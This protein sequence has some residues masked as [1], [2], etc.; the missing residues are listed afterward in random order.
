METIAY[1]RLVMPGHLNHSETL[2]GGDLLKWA[3]EAAALYVICQLKSKNVVTLKMSEIL[4]KE[5]VYNGDF[6]IFYANTK[7]VGNSSITIE[8]SVYKKDI[9]Q[10]SPDI[11]VLTCDF[12]FV[13]IDPLTKK[14][15]PH[16]LLKKE[17]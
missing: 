2:F 1:R 8:L 12:T 7:K 10:E 16:G 17:T 3:D 9:A 5:P 13:K 11:K 6:L 4:F 15:T 14:P